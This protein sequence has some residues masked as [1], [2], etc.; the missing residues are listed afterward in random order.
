MQA[1]LRQRAAPSILHA[2]HADHRHATRILRHRR[3]TRSRRRAADH[4]RPRHE[5]RLGGGS[6]ARAPTARAGGDRPAVLIGKDTR[7]SGYLLEAALE[8]GLSAAGVDVVPVRAAADAGHRV[9]DARAA[10]LGGHRHQR[11]AQP[12][13]RQRHQ[14][15]LA[16]GREAARRR[17]ERRSSARMDDAARLRRLG[18]ARQG[19]PRRRRGGALRRV[20]QEHVPARARPARLAHRRRLRARRGLPRRAAGVPRARRATVIA[21][22]VEPDGLNINAGNGATHPDFLAGEGASRIAPTSASRSTATATAW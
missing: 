12:V 9:P 16:G 8:A 22:G 2:R 17:R 19:A 18:R 6:H 14:V 11:V 10:A 1:R 15:L 3:R 20:L 4:A 21:V 13:R 7:I 5:A